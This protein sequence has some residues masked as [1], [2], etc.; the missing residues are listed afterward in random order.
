M[1]NSRPRNRR[2]RGG[3]LLPGSS[4]P[5]W[6]LQWCPNIMLRMPGGFFGGDGPG[7]FLRHNDRLKKPKGQVSFWE[8]LHHECY[9]S[10]HIHIG[11]A[12]MQSWK[13]KDRLFL[14]HQN[15]NDY[16][17]K[18]WEDFTNWLP[19]RRAKVDTG[20]FTLQ[21]LPLRLEI[22]LWESHGWKSGSEGIF[23]ETS[24]NDI[25]SNKRRP[26]PKNNPSKLASKASLPIPL[27]WC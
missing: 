24:L 16:S 7:D 8:F 14:E 15:E 13:V 25:A 5:F 9:I 22:N 12:K 3:F 10:S 27:G 20:L 23:L 6:F 19:K 4:G 1:E 2:N 17:P 26:I 11:F 18:T 21:T